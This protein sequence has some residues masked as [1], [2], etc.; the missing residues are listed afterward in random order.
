MKK[1]F[2]LFVV[3]IFY[4]IKIYE[5]VITNTTIRIREKTPL[6]IIKTNLFYSF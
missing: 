3:G 6:K 2:N 4:N 1:K 5:N